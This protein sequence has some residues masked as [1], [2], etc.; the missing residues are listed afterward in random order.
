MNKNS[1]SYKQGFKKGIE[2]YSANKSLGFDSDC[3]NEKTIMTC[4]NYADSGYKDGQIL[5]QTQIEFY[6]GMYDGIR[7]SYK[8][9]GIYIKE[10]RESNF[11]KREKIHYYGE[12]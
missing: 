2:I 8:Q 5:K 10:D 1:F 9:Y 4:K 12:Y 6:Y 7:Y 3:K 11:E